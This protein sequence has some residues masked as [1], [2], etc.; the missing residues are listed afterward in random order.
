[1]TLHEMP[2]K[3]EPENGDWLMRLSTPPIAALQ[4]LTLAPPI[5]RR[6]FTAEE[7]GKAAGW[8]PLVGGLLGCLLA[9]LDWGLMR[10]FPAEVS[11]VLVLAASAVVTGAL[12][13]D[14][15]LDAC[16]GLFGGYTAE[17][18][19]EIM[20]DERVGAFGL[21]GGVL[22]LLLKW[23]ALVACSERAVAIVLAFLLSRWAMTL[24]IALAPYA[25]AKGVGRAIKDHAGGAEVALATVIT[26]ASALTVG[27]WMGLLAIAWVG[28]VT[29]L[30]AHLALTKVPGLTGDLY[31]AL[32]ELVEVAVYLLFAA[33]VGI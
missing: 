32:S 9:G 11:S 14:G 26:L 19:L 12:H 30:G 28:I 13:L 27:R 4:F 29:W 7:V 31:G 25:R 24:S 1:V 6:P 18:R 22:L 8:F 10:I 23:A 17:K 2:E 33:H 5:I 21:V 20:R 15:F 16:D 3:P